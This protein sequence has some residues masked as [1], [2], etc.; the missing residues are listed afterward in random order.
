LKVDRQRNRTRYIRDVDTSL[1]LSELESDRQRFEEL[2]QE[3]SLR[4][5]AAK[6]RLQ[7][8]EAAANRS[9]TKSETDR[10]LRRLT[11][12]QEQFPLALEM[13]NMEEEAFRELERSDRAGDARLS[14]AAVKSSHDRT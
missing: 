9:L 2:R 6:A 3:A 13:A 10:M 8:I 14:Q 5:S 7:T 1:L 4:L 12:S 11:A